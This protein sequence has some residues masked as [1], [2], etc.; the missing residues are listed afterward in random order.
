MYLVSVTI[1][2]ITSNKVHK[3]VGRRLTKKRA[4]KLLE[5]TMIKHYVRNIVYYRVSEQ[6]K[7]SYYDFGSYTYFGKIE[8]I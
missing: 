8:K 5:K 6:G 4:L 2:S 7:V 1:G 3:V